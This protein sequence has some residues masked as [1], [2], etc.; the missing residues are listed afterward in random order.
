[1]R[2]DQTSLGLAERPLESTYLEIPALGRCSGLLPPG[3]VQTA[4]VD[5][6]EPISSTRRSTASRASFES[7][8][9]GSAIWPGV[10]GATPFSGLIR[11]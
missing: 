2:G 1:M 10:L 3:V 8:A 5:R 11:V 7:P 4:V 9:T 6:L